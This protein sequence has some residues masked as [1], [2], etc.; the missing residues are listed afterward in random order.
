MYD[1]IGAKIKGLSK[2]I[3]IIETIVSVIVGIMVYNEGWI[4]IGVIVMM[5]GPIVAWL[6][7]WLLYG[8]GELIDKTCDIARIVHGDEINSK[9]K[10][11]VNSEKVDNNEELNSQSVI[12][13]E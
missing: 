7:S 8:F 3:F 11:K 4:Y 10:P 12:T 6:L 2:A 5:V 1:N 9:I 13:E